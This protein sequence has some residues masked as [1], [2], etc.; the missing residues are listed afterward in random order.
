MN[1]KELSRWH[2]IGKL[3]RDMGNDKAYEVVSCIEMINS[4]LAY[5]CKGYKDAQAVRE[6][7]RNSYHDYLKP[8]CDKLGEEIVLKLIQNQI[9]S[10]NDVVYAGEDNEGVQYNSIV[11]K[12]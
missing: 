6:Y 8:Y 9:D 3:L 12:Y 1:D 2:R 10:I 7:E 5:N 4:C 11:W